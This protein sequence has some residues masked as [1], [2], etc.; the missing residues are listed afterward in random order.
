MVSDGVHWNA[1]VPP[2][3]AGAAALGL[4]KNV[5]WLAPQQPDVSMTGVGSGSTVLFNT[6]NNAS[7]LYGTTNGQ[8]TLVNAGASG[9]ANAEEGNLQTVTTNNSSMATLQGKLPT[10]SGSKAF[11]VEWA[12]STSVQNST[13]WPA[14]WL[15]CA[16]KNLG[17]TTKW[18]ELDVNESGQNSVGLW[19]TLHYWN[20]SS[21]TQATASGGNVDYTKTNIYGASFD[22]VGQ[23]VTWYVNGAAVGSQPFSSVGMPTAAYENLH[24]FM[25]ME[26]NNHS[27]TVPYE[28]YIEYFDAWVAP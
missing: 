23:R 5:L 20:G 24:F 16:E 13:I 4:T 26:A 18:M 10:L 15:W 2:L 12:M 22:P 7:E 9:N 3:P 11:Y 25:T 21:T 17:T 8:L 14:V 1:A 27:G 6:S 28:M 19:G